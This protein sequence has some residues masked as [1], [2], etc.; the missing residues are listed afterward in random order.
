MKQA[1]TLKTYLSKLDV[2]PDTTEVYIALTKLG[3][4]SALKLARLTKISRTQIYRHLDGL[5][6]LGLVSA[7]E[8]SYGTLFRALPLENIE[9][10]IA[11]REAENAAIKRNL[12]AM[13]E[14]LQQIAGS[15]G[16][17]AQVK[18]YYGLAGLKQV[19][20]N[21]TKADKEF[22][23]FEAAHLSQHLDI[24]FAR[25]CRER[26]IERGLTSYDLTN[27]SSIKRADLE[28]VEPTHSLFRYIDPQV[29]KLDFEVYLYNDVVTLLD[30]SKDNQTAL[31]IHHPALKKMMDQLF[32]AMW[33]QAKPLK[34]VS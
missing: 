2:D 18:H 14:A 10:V 11:N 26:F 3:L 9:A 32:D 17:K 13:A 24:A 25:R 6:A 19:N 4:T 29:L 20:W 30:Y 21:L 34:I 12:S 33:A 16:A 28:P 1:E 31:E 27:S 15:A 22:K 23:V 5:K 7:E 8:L